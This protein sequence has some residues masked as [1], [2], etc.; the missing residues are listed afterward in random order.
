[1]KH[2]ETAER[3]RYAME[4]KNMNARELAGKANIKEQSVSQ[5]INGRNKPSNLSAG[6]MAEILGVNPLWLMG[7]DVP[8]EEAR[9]TKMILTEEE[10]NL[11]TAYRNLSEDQRTLVKT[12]LKI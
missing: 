10:Y 3:L 2:Q 11:V 6:A 1:M 9:T 12:M 4:Q 7:F 8:M 5:Y